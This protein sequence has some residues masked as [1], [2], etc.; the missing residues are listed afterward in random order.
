[1]DVSSGMD[2]DIDR[3]PSPTPSS[4]LYM[5]PVA[6]VAGDPAAVTVGHRWREEIWEWRIGKFD[7]AC[8]LFFRGTSRW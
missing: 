7:M 3:S 1:M 4:P 2:F 6:A 5:R 8:V